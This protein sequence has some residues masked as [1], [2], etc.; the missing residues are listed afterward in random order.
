[1]I[2]KIVKLILKCKPHT[3]IYYY[4]SGVEIFDKLI[5]IREINSSKYDA[6]KYWQIDEIQSMEVE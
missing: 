5:C 4:A 2:L 1:M 3:P 6:N